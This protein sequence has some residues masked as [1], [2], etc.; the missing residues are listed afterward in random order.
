MRCEVELM[1]P[2]CDSLDG[3]VVAAARQALDAGDVDLV[4][5]YVPEDGEH[6][7]R[8]AFSDVLPLRG[9]GED[10]A[11]VAERWFFETVV[12]VH[13]AGE[14]APYTGLKPAGLDV[15]PVLPLAEKAVATGDID[16]VFR[17]LAA[18]LHAQLS[19]RLDR[20]TRL[21]GGRHDSVAAA[22]T[23][24]HAMLAF[25]VYA[26]HVL[27]ALHTDPHGEHRHA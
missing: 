6:E 2:H 11:A 20:V 19:H 7:V 13:R 21:A 8:D 26:N 25:E 16:D 4:L 17:L 1:P 3:P 22:R 15:G 24:V 27:H 23:Y 18:D 10:V 9:R 5:P 14:H 12:R